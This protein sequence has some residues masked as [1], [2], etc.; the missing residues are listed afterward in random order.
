[1]T[2]ADLNDAFSHFGLNDD[3]VLTL[4][5]TSGP[6]APVT[7]PKLQMQSDGGNPKLAA[8]A[9]EGPQLTDM[10]MAAIADA[11]SQR[12]GDKKPPQL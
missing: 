7:P 9:G 4:M 11:L 5:G 10:L 6:E 3:E 12:L 1:M 8:A 2:V